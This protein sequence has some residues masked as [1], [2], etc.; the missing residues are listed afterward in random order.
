M[1]RKRGGVLQKEQTIKVTA[2]QDALVRANDHQIEALCRHNQARRRFGPAPS[3][4]CKPVQ[5][6]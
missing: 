3:A 5:Q 6:F 1:W 4:K 2:A